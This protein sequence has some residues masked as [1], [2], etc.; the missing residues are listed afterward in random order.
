M[1]QALRNKELIYCRFWEPEGFLLEAHCEPVMAY[2]PNHLG[3][4]DKK[5]RDFEVSPG[6]SLARPHLNQWCGVCAC[7]TSYAGGGTRRMVVQDYPA[8]NEEMLQVFEK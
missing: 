5:G 7:Y 2:N 1:C 6:K 4:R 8:K 3:G